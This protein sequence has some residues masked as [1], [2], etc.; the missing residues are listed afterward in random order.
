MKNRTAL[1][2]HFADLGF[3]TGAEIGVH[4]GTFSGRML[5]MIPNLTLYA[6]DCWV[7]R[8]AKYE[9]AA[10]TS[11]A[12]HPKCTVIK[13]FSVDVA[14]TIPNGSLD[15]VYIDSNHFYESVKED[16]EA[17]APKVRSGGIVSGH[18][19]IAGRKTVQVIEAV[20]EYIKK[21][22]LTLHLTDWDNDNPAND[23]RQPSWYFVKP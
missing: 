9:E 5:T 11:L 2:Q 15:F 12:H 4:R 23:E 16:I 18:D 13:G 6:V 3:T 1:L 7:G 10:R 22:N 20:D 8:Y 14:E 17:W 21:N 19:Y